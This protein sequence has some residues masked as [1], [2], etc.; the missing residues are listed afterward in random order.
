MAN[1]TITHPDVAKQWH[2]TKNGDLKVEKFL[3][4]S[5]Q[6]IWWLCDKTNCSEKCIHEY[7]SQIRSRTNGTGCPYCSPN[8]L[9][10]CIHNSIEIKCPE[11][12]K[13]WHPIKNGVLHLRTFKTPMLFIK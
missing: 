11:L 9:K 6:K 7:Y 5:T 3:K 1:I 8:K 4:G 2:P 13:E 12:V 10:V